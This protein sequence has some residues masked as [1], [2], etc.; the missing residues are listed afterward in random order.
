MYGVS[1]LIP[2][3]PAPGLIAPDTKFEMTLPLQ[4]VYEL[5]SYVNTHYEKALQYQHYN[6]EESK[7][8]KK[9]I[10]VAGTKK[11]YDNQRSISLDILGKCQQK[12]SLSRTTPTLL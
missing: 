12:L 4:V 1:H 6:H 11:Q 7:K 2:R 10:I 9:R 5:S 8:F 3:T